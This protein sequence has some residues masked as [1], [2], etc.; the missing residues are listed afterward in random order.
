MTPNLSQIRTQFPEFASRTD[1][2]VET[3]LAEALQIQ[4]Y[5][6]SS[7]RSSADI[8]HILAL[9]S[10][11][12]TQPDAGAGI[13]SGETIGPR[14]VNYKTMSQD[15]HALDVWCEQ[16]HYGRMYLVL[17]KSNP[18]RTMGIVIG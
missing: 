8:I 14:Q 15:A 5:L 9:N 10:D 18:R 12:T 1:Q 4:G 13:V 16:T 11:E 17:A 2:Q 6:Q 3:A 7:G